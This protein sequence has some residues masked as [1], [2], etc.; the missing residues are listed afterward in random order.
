MQ[1]EKTE[2]ISRLLIILAHA[3]KQMDTIRVV[4]CKFVKHA[5]LHANHAM[6]VLLQTVLL[7]IQTQQLCLVSAFVILDTTKIPL[8]SSV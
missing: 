6:V 1:Q 3:I 7:V 4:V 8:H 5:M 2:L